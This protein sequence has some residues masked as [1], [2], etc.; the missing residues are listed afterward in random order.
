MSLYTSFAYCLFYVV[1]LLPAIFNRTRYIETF[2]YSRSGYLGKI[3]YFFGLLFFS[4][5]WLLFFD[6]LLDAIKHFYYKYLQ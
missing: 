3:V 5:F 6:L 2:L 4:F 1:F